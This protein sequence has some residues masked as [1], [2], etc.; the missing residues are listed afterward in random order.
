MPAIVDDE[1][2]T[3]RRPMTVDRRPAPAI[4]LVDQPAHRL[5]HGLGSHRGSVPH[6]APVDV[7]PGGLDDLVLS[8]DQGPIVVVGDRRHAA[9]SRRTMSITYCSSF[10]IPIA[11]KPSCTAA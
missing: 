2:L 11:W 4:P 8:D 5:I 1:T 10:S 6:D 3:I 7:D 9:L